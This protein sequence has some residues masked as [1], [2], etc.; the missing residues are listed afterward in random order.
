M[1]IALLIMEKSLNNHGIVFLN[2]C[3][4]PE[5]HKQCGR[6]LDW[7]FKPEGVTSLSLTGCTVF[8]FRVSI[9]ILCLILVCTQEEGNHSDTT[10][11]LLTGT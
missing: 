7:R 4:N 3:G 11:K 10:E 5:L 1:E 2:L 9:L 6:V 8:Y